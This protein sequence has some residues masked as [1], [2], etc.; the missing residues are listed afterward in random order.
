MKR[1]A[2]LFSGEGTNMQ[3]LI[4]KLHPDP[5]SVVTT[6]TNNPQAKG[7]TRSQAL[8]IEP[9]IIDHHDFENREAFDTKL[10]E[11][12]HDLRLDLV[13]LA[14]FMR[15]LT[16]VFTT[17][18]KAIN[19]HPSLLPMHKG[20]NAIQKSFESS[21]RYGGVTTHFVTAELDAGNIIMQKSFDKKSMNFEAFKTMIHQCEYEIFAPSVLKALEIL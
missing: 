13:V 17:Q 9:I 5:V 4:Q 6:I 10:V 12:L 14:G 15:I 18:I 1:I 7:I 3:T 11:I 2:I 20:A 16:P 8:G 21:D 19:I